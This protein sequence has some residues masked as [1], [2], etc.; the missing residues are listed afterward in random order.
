MD[1]LMPC[2]V[3]FTAF[4]NS[5]TPARIRREAKPK[6][7]GDE[8]EIYREF[9]HARRRHVSEFQPTKEQLRIAMAAIR[10]ERKAS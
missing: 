4:L 5:M 9:R 2:D 1:D 7:R 3:A 10:Q 8:L 6:F